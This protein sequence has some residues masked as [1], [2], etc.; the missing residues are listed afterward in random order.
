MIGQGMLGKKWPYEIEIHGYEVGVRYSQV[1]EYMSIYIQ[2]TQK[3]I[4]HYVNKKGLTNY[5]L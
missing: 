1:L 3:A 5:S 4:Y 2:F